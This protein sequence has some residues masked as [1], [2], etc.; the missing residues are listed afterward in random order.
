MSNSEE[1][2]LTE[3]I[4]NVVREEMQ[5]RNSSIR[6]TTAAN[7]YSRTQDVIRNAAADVSR[8]AVNS[9]T[10]AANKTKKKK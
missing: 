1:A 7:L 4:R 2:D 6:P 5:T 10:N 8:L 9:T 3:R